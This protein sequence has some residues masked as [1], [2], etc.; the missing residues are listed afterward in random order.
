M[1][2]RARA[3]AHT[4]THVIKNK[5]INRCEMLSSVPSTDTIAIVA[6]FIIRFYSLPPTLI[7]YNP[8]S[9]K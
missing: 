5:D 9:R 6:H 8:A 4:H 7:F 2:V 1:R 3:R